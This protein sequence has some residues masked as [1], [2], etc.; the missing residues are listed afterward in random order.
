[1]RES[2]RTILTAATVAAVIV[3][4]LP[5]GAQAAG[6][7]MTIVDPTSGAKAQVDG[8]KLRVGDGSGAMTVNGQVAARPALPASPFSISG[9]TTTSSE[10]VN[11]G[12][13]RIAITDVV[14][15][16]SDD[17]PAA[18]TVSVDLYHEGGDGDCT[19]TGPHIKAV[20]T[21]TWVPARETLAINLSTPVVGSGHPVCLVLTTFYEPAGTITSYTVTGYRT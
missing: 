4:L 3:L 19:T 11:L 13:G 6:Q 16:Q 20:L 14:L 5:V 8:G 7:L 12:S 18:I 2:T 10:F 21:D 15:S 17:T 9:D 1:M